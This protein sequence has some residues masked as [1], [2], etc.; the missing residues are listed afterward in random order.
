MVWIYGVNFSGVN[1]FVYHGKETASTWGVWCGWSFYTCDK[2]I[3]TF[4]ENFVVWEFY[5]YVSSRFFLL[6][7]CFLYVDNF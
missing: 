3:C 4:V 6:Q 2:V 1:R 5:V 7:F